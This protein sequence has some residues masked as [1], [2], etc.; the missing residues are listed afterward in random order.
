M[1]SQPK[2]ALQSPPE[3]EE[4]SGEKGA[5]TG[6]VGFF[7]QHLEATP[8]EVDFLGAAQLC[9]YNKTFLPTK[10]I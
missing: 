10:S 9:K 2:R 7:L 5:V 6:A 3:G 8:V 1:I 4:R